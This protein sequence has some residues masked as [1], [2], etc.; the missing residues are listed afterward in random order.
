VLPLARDAQRLSA[1]GEEAQPGRDG[2]GAGGEGGAGLDEV[3]AV[4][5]HEE[6]R[7]RAQVGQQVRR[8]IGARGE[9]EGQ[10]LRHRLG[11]ERGLGDAGQLDQPD[12]VGEARGQIGGDG[13]GQA[14]LAAAAHAG[15]GDQ[16]GSGERLGER[17][18]LALAPD[19]RGVHDREVVARRV[20]QRPSGDSLHAPS[21]RGAGR[22]R[23]PM[24]RV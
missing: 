21:R 10:G 4:V 6:E 15:H 9:P 18:A 24:A 22:V 1:G 23:C 17:G 13:E 11:D 7:A 19:Q 2:E 16:R 14:G 5:Q 8:R 3:L 20:G 12:A